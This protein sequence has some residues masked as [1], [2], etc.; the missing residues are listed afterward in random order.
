[1]NKDYVVKD[2][3][4]LQQLLGEPKEVVKQKVVNKLD[5]AMTNFIYRSPLLFIA[6]Y[7]RNGLPDISPK[8]DAPGFVQVTQEGTLLIPERLGNKLMFG[9]NN[10]LENNSVGL[11][12]VVPG[13]RETLRIKGKATLSRDPVW[14]QALA[15]QGKPA[16]LCTHVEVA[17]CFFH[18]GKAMIRSNLWKPENWL[19]DEKLM[20]RHFA[21][22]N[23]LDQQQIETTLEQSYEHNLY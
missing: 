19:P 5:E 17:E 11:I 14:L 1:M 7:A 18:C 2:T 3:A 10:I 4:E 20:A 9:F 6:S 13:T 16:L 23:D 12:F 15:A 21:N 22:K 8:G